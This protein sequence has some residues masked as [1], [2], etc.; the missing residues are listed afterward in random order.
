MKENRNDHPYEQTLSGQEQ[1]SDSQSNE[2]TLGSEGSPSFSGRERSG[3]YS[4]DEDDD[5]DEME[6]DNLVSRTDDEDDDLSE[7]DENPSMNQ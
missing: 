5:M 7:N 6:E 2:G 4:S 1:N 3:E